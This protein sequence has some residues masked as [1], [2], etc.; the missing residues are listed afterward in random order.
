MV[1]R[2]APVQPSGAIATDVLKACRSAWSTTREIAADADCNVRTA[3]RWV[4]WYEDAGAITSRQCLRPIRLAGK[5]R[6]EY[7]IAPAWRH[8]AMPD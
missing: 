2:A 1:T 4:Q 5:H 6:I 7:C 8:D 3:A